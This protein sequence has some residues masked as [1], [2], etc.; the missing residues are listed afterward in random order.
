[1]H[2]GLSVLEARGCRAKAGEGLPLP[3]LQRESQSGHPQPQ[4]ATGRA[5]PAKGPGKL[6]GRGH[7]KWP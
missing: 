1:M 6:W 5:L 4:Q 2:L 3:R 7:L